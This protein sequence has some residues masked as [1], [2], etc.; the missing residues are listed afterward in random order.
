[1]ISRGAVCRLGGIALLVIWIWLLFQPVS[2]MVIEGVGLPAELITPDQI[3]YEHGYSAALVGWLYAA[4]PDPIF[5]WFA[6]PLGLWCLISML[7]GCVPNLVA[8]LLAAGLAPT[9]LAPNHLTWFDDHGVNGP[10][11]TLAAAQ[12]WAWSFV[13]PLAV[14]VVTWGFRLEDSRA[15]TAPPGEG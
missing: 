14:R 5:A 4:Q 6:N 2:F 12:V 11:I 10:T 3:Q 9:G 7:R 1:M 8:A 15:R 13:L